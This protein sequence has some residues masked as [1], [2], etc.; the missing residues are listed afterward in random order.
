MLIYI[1]NSLQFWEKKYNQYGFSFIKN[2]WLNSSHTIGK[3]LEVEFEGKML[4]GSFFGINDNGS[5]NILVGKRVV[6]IN[7]GDVFIL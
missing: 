3:K 5:L 7:V 4:E 1:A 2:A 6:E